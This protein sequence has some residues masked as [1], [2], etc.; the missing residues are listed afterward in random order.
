MLRLLLMAGLFGLAMFGVARAI[1]RFLGTPA[2]SPVSGANEINANPVGRFTR[3]TDIAAGILWPFPPPAKVRL[4][5]PCPA[6][7]QPLLGKVA[8]GEELICPWCRTTFQTPEP[9]PAAPPVSRKV[10]KESRL[11][12][13]FS[14]KSI[15]TGLSIVF[16]IITYTVLIIVAVVD[17]P[18]VWLLLLGIL[19]AGWVIQALHR[20]FWDKKEF[21]PATILGE[22]GG[23]V[24]AHE[25]VRTTVVVGLPFSIGLVFWVF[26]ACC[27]I[28]VF[29]GLGGLF[30]G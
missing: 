11:K 23:N 28:P 16:G 20:R 1:R 22:G 19:V 8:P 15:I 5:F 9:P 14:F 27:L 12:R 30:F 26:G 21:L 17:E 3:F 7:Y 4:A 2:T 6:C 13:S 24:F 25:M 10:L 29:G 18:R